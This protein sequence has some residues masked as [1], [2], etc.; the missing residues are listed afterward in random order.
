[1]SELSEHLHEEAW[2]RS[3]EISNDTRHQLFMQA[4]DRIEAL[5]AENAELQRCFD[6]QWAAQQR[7]IKRWQEATG[8]DMAWP[9]HAEL[10]LWMLEQ[11][12]AADKEGMTDEVQ[13]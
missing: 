3:S 4:A 1:M 8:R 2:K 7:A 9:D 12:D 13:K 5:E 11:I 10:I 6:L